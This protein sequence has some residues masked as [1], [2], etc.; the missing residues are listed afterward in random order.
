VKVPTCNCQAIYRICGDFKIGGQIIH[1]RK[2]ADD[3]V[4]LAEEEKVLKDITDNLIEIGR[5]YRM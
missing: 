1:T 2:Y 3:L 5:S 4:L